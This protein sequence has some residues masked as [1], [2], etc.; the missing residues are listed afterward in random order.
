MLANW[1]PHPR[2][3][4]TC[5]FKAGSRIRRG[6]KFWEKVLLR[7]KHRIT[8]FSPNCTPSLFLNQ[9]YLSIKNNGS[10]ISSSLKEKEKVGE[11]QEQQTDMM[12]F[13]I[14]RCI[15]Q[16]S[17]HRII[18]FTLRHKE[19]ILSA[20]ALATPRQMQLVQYS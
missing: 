11:K 20:C 5:T 17:W 1:Y 15:L 9:P 6:C 12:L 14:E 19:S 4:C 16:D 18:C 7:R 10:G 3:D 8:F 13:C 2:G